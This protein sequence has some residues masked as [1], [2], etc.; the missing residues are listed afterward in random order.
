MNKK[1]II[2]IILILLI[3]VGAIYGIY[4]VF[5]QIKIDNSHIIYKENLEVEVYDTIN[6]SKLVKYI[7][8]EIL[9]DKLINTDNLGN[10]TIQFLYQDNHKK[11]KYGTVTISV[12]DTTKPVIFINDVYTISKD[13]DKSLTNI[14]M[15]VDNYDSNPKREIIGDYNLKIEGNYP[16]VYQVSDSSGNVSKKEFTLK[17]ID[18]NKIEKNKEEDN[19]N[20]QDIIKN[21]KKEN[22]LIGIDVSKWQEEIDFKKVKEAGAE[23]VMIKIGSQDG[24][25]G[26]S[27]LDPYFEKNIQKA[28]ES[29]LKIGI[30]YYSHA[31]NITDATD[32][33]NWVLNQIS[34]YKIDLPI[35]FDWENW[36]N[37]NSY[38][39]S[40]HD[41]NYIAETFL[42]II[43]EKGYSTMLYSSKYYLE[44]IWNINNQSTW[45]AHYTKQTNYDR[46]YIM[47][48][49]CSNGKIDGIKPY[50]DIDILYKQ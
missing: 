8:G 44:N 27:I 18:S 14:L 45:L 39:V 16:L 29:E 34:K 42:N 9:E 37:F 33:A 32:Q 38:S 4:T 23:F 20:F 22:N 28:M 25:D 13:S 21:Y 49:I 36:N 10:Q 30:Y 40:L 41:I 2:F 15:S 19:T 12:V 3:F 11:K 46:D 47:W 7:S 35:A 43:K 26:E 6:V 48:Q 17:V 50:V 31:R 24:I 1:T 5:F